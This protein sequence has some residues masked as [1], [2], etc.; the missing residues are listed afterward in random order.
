MSEQT[1]HERYEEA[2]KNGIWRPYDDAQM[3]AKQ[4]QVDGLVAERKALMTQIDG[5]LAER[6]AILDKLTAER[7]DLR[8]WINEAS[9]AFR[10]DG[11]TDMLVE[12]VARRAYIGEIPGEITTTLVCDACEQEFAGA[13][14]MASWYVCHRCGGDLWHKRQVP[15]GE[16]L[17]GGSNAKPE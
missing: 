8:A 5:L 16:T 4:R 15:D 7:D 6:Q 11:G 14:K 10:L 17:D 13:F 1:A 9:S 12:V 2:V 3:A